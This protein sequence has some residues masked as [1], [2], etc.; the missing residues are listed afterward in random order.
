MPPEA[1]KPKTTSDDITIAMTVDGVVYHLN[2]RELDHITE[3]ALFA[4]AGLTLPQL[5][6]AMSGGSG[7]PF[8]LAAL[9]FLARR[10]RGD[11]VTYDEVASAIGT[12]PRSTFSS[13]RATRVRPRKP[14]APTEESAPRAVALV[15]AQRRRPRCDARSGDRRIPAATT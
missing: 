4:E 9:V 15:R 5:M 8:M 11:R 6:T 10:Q 7:A 13:T 12:T 3:R 14:Q 2:P 1:P